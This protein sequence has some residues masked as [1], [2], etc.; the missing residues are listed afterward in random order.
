MVGQNSVVNNVP[1]FRQER[2][3]GNKRSENTGTNTIL[4]YHAFV[5]INIDTEHS[6]VCLYECASHIY[7]TYLS[8]YENVVCVCSMLIGMM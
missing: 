4:N 7:I 8:N 3:R 1:Q 2:G 5:L 6:H